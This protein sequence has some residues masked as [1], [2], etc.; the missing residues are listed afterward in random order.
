MKKLL[1]F[2]WCMVAAL[3]VPHLRAATFSG[4]G[5][6][7]ADVSATRT[8]TPYPSTATVSGLAAGPISSVKISLNGLTH[9]RPDDIGLLLVSPWGGQLIILA[10]A[11][12]ASVGVNNITLTFDDA[13]ASLVADAGPM[14]AGS[15]KPTCVDAQNNIQAEF[16]GVTGP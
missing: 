6:T 14:V 5:V 12:G 13:A 9:P 1:I 15:F 10:D 8:G 7:F 3:S 16:P 2:L 4:A 11:G